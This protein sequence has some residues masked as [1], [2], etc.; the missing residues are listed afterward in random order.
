MPPPPDAFAELIAPLRAG[1][2]DSI[3]FST[4]HRRKDGSTYPVE[5]HLQLVSGEKPLFVSII[6]DLT[7]REQAEAAATR[8]AQ[9]WQATVDATNSAIWIKDRNQRM[10]R[11][12][13]MAEQLFRQDARQTVLGHCTGNEPSHRRLSV[14]EGK[15]NLAPRNHGDPNE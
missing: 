4:I 13:K 14:Y 2:K 15:E 11:S 3:R 5:V 12:N 7:E 9:E 1:K 8:A 10:L 6:L